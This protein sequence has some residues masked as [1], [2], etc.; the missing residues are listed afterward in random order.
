MG[1]TRDLQIWTTLSLS[2]SLSVCLSVSLYGFTLNAGTSNGVQ[3]GSV[4]MFDDDCLENPSWSWV[5]IHATR[6]GRMIQTF[7]VWCGPS[8]PRMVG[9]MTVR[10][11]IDNKRDE[12]MKRKGSWYPI[13]SKEIFFFGQLV[14]SG[15]RQADQEQSNTQTHT[16]QQR[17]TIDHS[18]LY[19]TSHDST[20]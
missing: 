14:I 12:T 5:Y 19:T 18:P 1:N 11:Y 10:I 2:L 7:Y 15:G 20:G 16:S 13:N 3:L 17:L 4:A 8:M 6:T 9:S